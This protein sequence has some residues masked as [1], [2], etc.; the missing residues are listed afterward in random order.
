MA[1]IVLGKRP[2][3]FT[4]KVTFPMLDGTEGVINC[5]FKYRTKTEFGELL[6]K[7]GA[8]VGAAVDTEKPFSLSDFYGGVNKKN[9][10]HLLQILEGWDVE[11]DLTSESVEQLADELPAAGA[12]IAHAYQLGIVEGRLGN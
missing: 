5:V 8:N 2:K 11:A 3:S 12:A 1:K 6:D 9:A 4:R 10:E 7:L